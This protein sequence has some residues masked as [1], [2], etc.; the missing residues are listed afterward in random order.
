MLY[1]KSINEFLNEQHSTKIKA[2]RG[3]ITSNSYDV[4]V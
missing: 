3:V 2:Y 4:N 1:I